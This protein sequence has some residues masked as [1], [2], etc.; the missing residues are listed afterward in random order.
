MNK[1]V[2]A[3][4]FSFI[5][6]TASAQVAA[7]TVGTGKSY[8]ES[9]YN[10]YDWTKKP[11][12]STGGYWPGTYPC[13]GNK[14]FSKSFAQSAP[15]D[16]NK[17]KHPATATSETYQI[18]QG[19]AVLYTDN[20]VVISLSSSDMCD[21]HFLDGKFHSKSNLAKNMG[22][23]HKTLQDGTIQNWITYTMDPNNNPK[24]SKV[25]M[26]LN[27]EDCIITIRLVNKSYVEKAITYF[28]SEVSTSFGHY[29]YEI[30]YSLNAA[31]ASN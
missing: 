12:C 19:T 3:I 18:T 7:R 22:A 9:G 29:I 17:N 21:K 2:F 14:P 23:H 31:I 28:G 20:S 27:D 6:T 8:A 13:L 24:S 4:L 1:I 16:W 15:V 30:F 11:E 25:Q 10:L 5:T 26:L